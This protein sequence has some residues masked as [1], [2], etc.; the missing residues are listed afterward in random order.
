MTA[1]H[2][3]GANPYAGD[4]DGI[5][6][7]EYRQ[8]GRQ[9]L[10]APAKLVG[11]TTPQTFEFLREQERTDADWFRLC[12][13]LQRT[14]RGLPA[15][16]PSAIASAGMV[17]RGERVTKLAQLS[18][19]MAAYW[20]V[21][22][23]GH[24]AAVIRRRPGTATQTPIDSSDAPASHGVGR[25]PVEWFAEHWGADFLFGAYSINGF[26]LRHPP[27]VKPGTAELIERLNGAIAALRRADAVAERRDFPGVEAAI[28][29]DI[30]R[31]SRRVEQLRG[32]SS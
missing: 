31:M 28:E 22:D 5:Q 27:K 13:G 20:R 30:E 21:G 17:P 14:A 10:A 19:G 23:F 12:L 3:H 11:A 4:F 29:A 1:E 32:A 25:V 18:R 16:A 8:A 26:D 9:L 15:V 6:D 24:I 7:H 2:E